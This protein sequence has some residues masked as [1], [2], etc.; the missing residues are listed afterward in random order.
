MCLWP[1]ARGEAV[2]LL[3][4]RPDYDGT[5]AGQVSFP[6][7]GEERADRGD[8]VATALR[9]AREET[10]LD[11]AAC[12]L[13]VIGRLE[14]LWIPPS[15]YLV[16]PVVAIAARRPSLVADPREV[17]AILHA[18]LDRFVPGAP[19]VVVE[20][21]I[22]GWPLRYGAYDVEGRIVWGATARILAQLGA[23]LEGRRGR[24]EP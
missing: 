18:P 22:R 17:A 9:E 14:Q 21:T 13:R 1:D 19:T 10:G 5:H 11:P 8:P 3:T 12:G 20:N 2:V 15:N 4:E 16:V 23:I 24:D 7:G 6:G